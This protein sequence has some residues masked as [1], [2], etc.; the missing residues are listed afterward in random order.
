[1]AGTQLRSHVATLTTLANR[2]LTTLW[3]HVSTAVEAHQAL[4]DVLPALI[5]QYGAAA[6]TVAAEWYDALRTK[7]AVRG[8]FTAIPA[9]ATDQGA[10]ALAGWATTQAVDMD[11][12]L[13]LVQGGVQRR[14]ANVARLTVTDSTIQDPA[15]DGWQRVGSGECA[16]CS[17]LIGRGVVFS[18]ASA[19]FASHDHC[20]CSAVPAFGGLPRPVKPFTPSQR[21]RSEATR[22][23][24]NERARKWIAA[25]A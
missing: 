3:Q 11:S 24:D 2:D 16:F 13:T 4:Q 23:K 15:A 25:N 17:M 12:M 14:I 9:E 1:M 18:E 10:Q 8:R 19:D 5:D 21:K 6:G 22:S 20:K 7:L